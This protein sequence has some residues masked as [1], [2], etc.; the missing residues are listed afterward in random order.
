MGVV[1]GRGAQHGRA[2]DVDHLDR[3]VVARAA[4]DRGLERIEVD[5]QQ[6]DLGD[7]LRGQCGHMRGVVAPCQQ[8]AVHAGMQ[9]LDPA[10]EDL[11][12]AG[13]IRHLAH[14]QPLGPQQ[15]R[16]TAGRD[17]LDPQPRQPPRQIDQT[18]LVRDR[19]QRAAGGGGVGHR[20]SLNPVR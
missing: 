16:R 18:G 6:I 3:L 4:G 11:G 10:V 12:K 14:G 20:C 8:A 19:D 1:L 7:P 9:R 17:Q 2:A 13:Q 5:D 15:P